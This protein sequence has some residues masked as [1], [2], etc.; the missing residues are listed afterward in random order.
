MKRML[1]LLILTA[2]I[3]FAQETDSTLNKW[4]PSLVT[5]FN[6][7]QIAFSNWTKGGTNSITWSLT[8]DFL[9]AYK[10]LDWNFKNQLKS[11]YGQT[12]VGSDEFITNDNELYLESVV[13]KNIGWIID[14]Y[15]SNTVRTQI[16]K[17]Y[18]LKDATK[19]QI[20]DM[21]DPGYITQSL[22]FA[23][24]RNENFVTRLGVAI[25]EVITNK[26]TGYSDDP[27]TTEIEKFKF[28]TGLE[29]VTDAQTVLA[30]NIMG[31][32]KLRLF[33][34]FESLDVWDVWW[35]NTITAK[36]NDWLNV[37]FTYLLVYQLDQSPT[38]QMKQALQLGIVYTLL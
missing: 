27:E 6:I 10:S 2:S 4:T 25:Q 19:T 9:I 3:G 14:P 5:G 13:S 37:N 23:Y 22:G 17:G 18:D 24:D 1:L 28:E 15:F 38:A 29:S 34:R 31:K 35:D 12:K 20:S 30:E 7:N 32:T 33:S 26:F 8:E 11:S 16:T 21:F 36:V